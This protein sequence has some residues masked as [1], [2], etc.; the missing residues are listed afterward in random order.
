MADAG[1]LPAA[2]TCADGYSLTLRAFEPDAAPRRALLLAPATGVPAGF[3][4][5]F[6]GWMAERGCAC[7]TWDWR[8]TGENARRAPRHTDVSMLD[9]ATLDLPAAIDWTRRRYALPLTGIGHSFG[10]QAFGLAD[11]P[12]VFASIVLFASGHAYWRH[13]PPPGRYLFR[14]S[15]SAL[16]AITRVAGYLPGRMLGL[17]ADLPA[18]VARQWLTWCLQPEYCGRWSGHARIKAPV[19]SYAFADDGYAPAASRAALLEKYGGT[20]S[21]LT[22]RPVDFG[23]RRVGHLDFFRRRHADTLWP[24]FVDAL[25]TLNA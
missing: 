15:I 3:Y 20:K 14:A 4:A 8:G 22:P 18:G 12:D 24:S 13:W 1:G 23:L 9:W 21:M 7:V 10:G 11:R 5:G 17:G 25:E 19:L 2:V 6:A 16:L